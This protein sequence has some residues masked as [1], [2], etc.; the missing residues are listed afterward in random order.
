[1]PTVSIQRPTKIC[2]PKLFFFVMGEFAQ[3]DHPAA[4]AGITASRR[5][6]NLLCLRREKRRPQVE[7]RSVR[8]RVTRWVF[9]NMAQ[10]VAQPIFLSNLIDNFYCYVERRRPKK[11]GQLAHFSK[12]CP[13]ETIVQL[14]IKIA[15]SS[16]RGLGSLEKSYA[17]SWQ[18]S[19]LR[20]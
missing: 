1:M 15:Q 18:P 12:Y 6:S 8:N 16:H 5:R 9:E 4:G 20:S 10:N 7:S 14:A 19:R 3:S 17:K 11:F 2:I 13:K